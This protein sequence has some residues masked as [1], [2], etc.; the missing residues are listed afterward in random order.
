VSENLVK[1]LAAWQPAAQQIAAHGYLDAPF[2][3]EAEA[4][5]SNAMPRRPI[6]ETQTG[7]LQEEQIECVVAV[8]SAWSTRPTSG[9]A[10]VAPEASDHSGR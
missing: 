3:R 4:K 9:E 6:S 2:E 1:L 5:A 8:I 7:S 10:P